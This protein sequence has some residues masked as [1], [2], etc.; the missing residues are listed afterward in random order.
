MILTFSFY[1]NAN[2]V[3]RIKAVLQMCSVKEEKHPS[4]SLLCFHHIVWGSFLQGGRWLLCLRRGCTSQKI[5][6]IPNAVFL[7][8]IHQVEKLQRCDPMQSAFV[9]EL[10]QFCVFLLACSANTMQGGNNSMCPIFKL[11]GAKISEKAI[12]SHVLES[13]E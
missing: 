6:G 5:S 3:V 13:P 8:C 11:L 2:E 12:R 7:P 4:V 9:H 10:F 1:K